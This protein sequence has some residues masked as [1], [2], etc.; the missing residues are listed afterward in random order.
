MKRNNLRGDEKCKK[1]SSLSH[2]TPKIKCQMF[3]RTVQQMTSFN[4]ERL[5]SFE[6]GKRSCL[7]EALE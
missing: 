5:V 2:L 7:G 1:A 4:T 3:N 6:Q